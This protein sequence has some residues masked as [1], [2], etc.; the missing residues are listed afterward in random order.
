MDELI[1]SMI[2]SLNGKGPG[3][4][5]ASSQAEWRRRAANIANSHDLHGQRAEDLRDTTGTR[6]TARI[7]GYAI[8]NEWLDGIERQPAKARRDPDCRPSGILFDRPSA[9]DATADFAATRHCQRGRSANLRLIIF[10]SRYIVFVMVLINSAGARDA[11][12]DRHQGLHTL[13]QFHGS[14]IFVPVNLR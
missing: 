7:S 10:R 9:A 5:N 8:N 12:G 1:N 13:M 3:L 6:S 11:E 14:I 2:A 4:F